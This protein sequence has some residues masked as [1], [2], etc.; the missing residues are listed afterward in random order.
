LDDLEARGFEVGLHGDTHD[1]AIG[2][3]DMRS[4][5]DRLRRCL[6]ALGHPVMG[7]RAPAL[8]FSEPLLA[9]L[10]ELGFRYDS[11]IKANVYYTGGIDL[12]I[13][14]LY[15]GTKMWEFPLVLQDDGLFRDQALDEAEALQVVQDVVDALRPYGGL[16][17]FNSHPIHLRP[18][19]SFYRRLLVW[20][21]DARI[22][23][24]LARDLVKALDETG[25]CKHNDT[26]THSPIMG[27]S[28][29][30]KQSSYLGV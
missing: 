6:D 1:M 28:E 11:S 2:F 20:F 24:V 10:D 21:A 8:A 9:V 12:C 26:L 17:V 30:H 15:P 3:R 18:R 23:V 16:V 13:P 14:Y 19:L 4:V 5:R 29:P 25:C 7:Y 22:E 27:S